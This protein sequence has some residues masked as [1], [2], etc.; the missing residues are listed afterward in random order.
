MK[1][2][3]LASLILGAG[4]MASAQPC[5]TACGSEALKKDKIPLSKVISEP[6]CLKRAADESNEDLAKQHKLTDFEILARLVF[7]EG[8]ST[9]LE[10]CDKYGASLFESLAW[11]VENRV[12]LAKASPAYAKMFGSGIQGVI[13][14]K[15]QFNPA[16]SKKSSYSKLFL[17]PTEHPEW[18]KYWAYSTQA[19]DKVMQDPKQNPFLKA[20][21][22]KHGVSAVT[23]FYYPHSSQATQPP[24]A[25]ADLSKSAA[26][27]AYVKAVSIDGHAYSN[28]CVQF[29][30]Y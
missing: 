29:F 16:V 20:G 14:K 24:V 22:Q 21:P 11:G 19:A 15:A 8:I 28:E 9:N 10:K 26:K 6:A 23:H 13:F 27:K 30:S 7:A 4:L 18:K 17:C 12:A 2:V 3:L 5:P 1:T 25:W